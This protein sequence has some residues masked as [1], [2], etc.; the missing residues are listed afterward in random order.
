M[1]N[2]WHAFDFQVVFEAVRGNGP[3]GDIA[4]DDVILKNGACPSPGKKK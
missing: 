1:L 4:F 3:L 2:L